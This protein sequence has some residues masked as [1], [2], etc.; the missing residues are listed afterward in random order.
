MIVLLMES[1]SKLISYLICSF[2]TVS[3]NNMQ[4]QRQKH[5]NPMTI[6]LNLKK[7]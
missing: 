7:N 1:Q 4:L 5:V 2:A 3:F 6:K